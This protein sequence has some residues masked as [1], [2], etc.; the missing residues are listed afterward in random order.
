MACLSPFPFLY[1][2]GALTLCLC[3]LQLKWVQVCVLCGAKFNCSLLWRRRPLARKR[4]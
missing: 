3:Y 1:V 2:S 4:E